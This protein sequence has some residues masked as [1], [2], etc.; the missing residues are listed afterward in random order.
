[1]GSGAASGSASPT[2]PRTS[3]A[4][5]VYPRAAYGSRSVHSG[6]LPP[7][8][9]NISTAGAGSPVSRGLTSF[10]CTR[11]PA[12][13]VKYRCS[14]RANGTSNA[15]GTSSTRASTAAS[16]ARLLSQNSSKSSGRGFV[17]V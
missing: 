7:Y 13:P 17:P 1:M 5:I 15:A 11:T 2:C 4:A 6:A 3:S 8:P 16:S 10:A 14:Q 12:V 9:W